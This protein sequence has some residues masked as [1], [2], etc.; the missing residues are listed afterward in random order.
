MKK[1][2]SLLLIFTMLLTLFA[3]CKKSDGD[4]NTTEEPQTPATTDFPII[5]DGA[6]NVRVI[7]NFSEVSKNSGLQSRIDTLLSTIE[8]KTGVEIEPLN[9]VASNYDP[10]TF[11]IYIGSTEYAETL[12]VTDNLRLKDYAITRQGNKLIIAAGTPDALTTA[13]TFFLNGIINPQLKEFSGNLVFKDEQENFHKA[14]Y[15]AENILINGV[16]LKDFTLVL[17]VNFEMA[18]QETAY[19]LRDLISVKYGYVL[20]VK[21]D[22]KTYEHEILIGQTARTTI[23]SPALTEYTVEI[24]DQNVQILAGCTSAYDY[25]DDLFENDFLK[26]SRVQT[27]KTDAIEDYKANNDAILGTTG[28][29]RIIFQNVYGAESP[30]KGVN[31]NPTLRWNLIANLYGEYAP[32]IICMQE[33]NDLCRTDA[34]SLAE[35]LKALGYQEITLKTYTLTVTYNT[36]N[37]KDGIASATFTNGGKL[38]SVA[39]LFYNPNKL[40]LVKYGEHIFESGLTNEEIKTLYNTYGQNL[41]PNN[42]SNL[43]SVAPDNKATQQQWDTERYNDNVRYNQIS[44]AVVWAIFKDKTTSKLFAVASVHLDHQNTS[45]ANARRI[46]QAAELLNVIN[47]EILVGEYANIPVILGGD[48]NS[49]YNRENDQYNN[50]GALHSLEA[51]GFSDV[52]STFEGADQIGTSCGYP[53]FDSDKKYFTTIGSTVGTAKGA[54]DHC[55]YKGDVEVTLFDIMSDNY[56]RRTSDH[57]PLVVDFNFK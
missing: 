44:K 33:F 47:T 41:N 30:S 39:T 6:L 43:G 42:H 24:T 14:K 38:H 17:P 22:R 57:L 51:A 4:S 37:K 40:E 36:S 18:E 9:C 16:D 10:E 25:I 48:I 1:L 49:S 46:K 12:A 29:I 13:I 5:V 52:Q 21:N 32:D 15:D 56:A 34:D 53:N 27:V 54:I 2:L 35:R 55:F 7:Y 50:T 45:Y 11:D 26:N 31:T 28:D 8:K 20:P 3:A 19:I 23:A